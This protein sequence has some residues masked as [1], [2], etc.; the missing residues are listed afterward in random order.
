MSTGP[1]LH[2]SNDFRFAG[3]GIGA[4]LIC[5]GTAA[6]DRAYVQRTAGSIVEGNQL[7]ELAVS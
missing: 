6:S 2:P 5:D 3:R 1:T 7:R 4:K